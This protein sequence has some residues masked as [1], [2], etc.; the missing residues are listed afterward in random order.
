MIEFGAKFFLLGTN[1]GENGAKFYSFF[2][3]K[4]YRTSN[5]VIEATIYHSLEIYHY[6]PYHSHLLFII[7]KCHHPAAT[8]KIEKP[9]ILRG[10][11]KSNS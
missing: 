2:H 11:E 9:K 3:K 10:K 5:F 8:C 6:K 4:G 7:I 1:K